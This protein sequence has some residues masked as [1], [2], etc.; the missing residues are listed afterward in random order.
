RKP[1]KRTV[2]YGAKWEIRF[3]PNNRFRAFY[4]IDYDSE[5]VILLAI[6]E[7]LGNRLI[8]GGEEVEL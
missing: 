6:G 5:Q 4:R 7:K 8:I 1:L 3:G 2:V